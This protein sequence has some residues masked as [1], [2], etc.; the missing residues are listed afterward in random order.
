MKRIISACL[1]QTHEFKSNHDYEVFINGLNR[2]RI[3]YKIISCET[4][5]NNSIILKIRKQYNHYSL[6]DYL[7]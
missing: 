6:G 4:Q 5:P 3:K 2:K 7:K 1:D